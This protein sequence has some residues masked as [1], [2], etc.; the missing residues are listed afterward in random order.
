MPKING[1]EVTNIIKAHSKYTITQPIPLH[2]AESFIS[3]KE[4][5]CKGLGHNSK[6]SDSHCVNPA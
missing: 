4:L 6:D 5:P 2:F 1:L 3:G